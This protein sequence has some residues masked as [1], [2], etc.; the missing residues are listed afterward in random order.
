MNG[1]LTE[2]ETAQSTELNLIWFRLKYVIDGYDALL[3]KLHPVCYDE[4]PTKEESK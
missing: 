1:C 4:M 2:K 3:R